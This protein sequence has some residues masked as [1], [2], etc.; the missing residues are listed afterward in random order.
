MVGPVNRNDGCKGSEREMNTR[1]TNVKSEWHSSV[2]KKNND[3]R[4][5]VSL[6]LVQINIERTIKT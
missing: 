4:N 3:L 2:T 1:E 6:E 5:Q